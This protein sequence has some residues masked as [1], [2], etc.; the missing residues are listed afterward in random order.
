M[1]TDRLEQGLAAIGL[2]FVYEEIELD[3][4]IAFQLKYDYLKASITDT[5]LSFLLIKEKRMG[6]IEGVIKQSEVLSQ[7][8][9]LPYILVFSEIPSQTKELLLKARIP[10]IDYKGNMFIPDL[11]LVLNKE[12]PVFKDQLF[13]PSEQVVLIYLLFSKSTE[14]VPAK[15]A[16]VLNISVPTVYRVLKNFTERGWLRSAYGLY[17]FDKEKNDIYEEARKWLNNPVKKCVFLD[18]SYFF[19]LL[20]NERIKQELKSA[21]LAALSQLS[22]LDDVTTT[23]ALT[24]KTYNKLLKDKQ[25]DTRYILDEK[26]KNEVEL[27]LWEYRPFTVVGEKIVDPISLMLSLKDFDDPRVEIELEKMDTKI[28]KKLEESYA[29]Q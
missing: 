20:S 21:G 24:R 14:I 23:F 15:I 22:M 29:H 27:Q 26:V 17:S 4:P 2:S 13:S 11:G 12:L 8:A 5:T 25:L 16:E 7:K 18:R 9:Q 28:V 6:S 19:S 1:H 10:F 3:V